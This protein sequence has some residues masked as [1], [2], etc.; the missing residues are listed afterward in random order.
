M[1]ISEPLLKPCQ[2]ANQIGV[3]T[4]TIQKWIAKGI[5]P[6]IRIEGTTRVRPADL[7]SLLE[8]QAVNA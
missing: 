8:K 5:L 1:E 6:A 2:V 7:Q 3:C 4:R